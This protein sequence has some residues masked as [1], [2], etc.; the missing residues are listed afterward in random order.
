MSLC[1]LRNKKYFK[2]KKTPLFDYQNTSQFLLKSFPVSL[3]IC[4]IGREIKIKELQM[5]WI[6]KRNSFLSISSQVGKCIANVVPV[7]MD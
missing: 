7:P 3:R 6:W 1:D 2:Q 5:N 4:V